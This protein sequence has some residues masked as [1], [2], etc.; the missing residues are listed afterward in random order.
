M[1]RRCGESWIAISGKKSCARN[2]PSGALL[3]ETRQKRENAT[4]P[5]HARNRCCG[6]CAHLR[7]VVPGQR[8]ASA[9]VC[10]T[11]R[12]RQRTCLCCRRQAPVL[13]G[14]RGSAAAW[15]VDTGELHGQIGE[16]GTPYDRMALSPKGDSAISFAAFPKDQVENPT[17]LNRQDNGIACGVRPTFDNFPAEPLGH[18][19]CEGPPEPCGFSS[20]K[21]LFENVLESG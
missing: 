4:W 13:R 15:D 6:T 3:R 19:A 5:I 2:P 8:Q 10:G 20:G 7:P 18:Q 12:D 11:S 9:L 21:Y 17:F 14:V 16:H 1:P